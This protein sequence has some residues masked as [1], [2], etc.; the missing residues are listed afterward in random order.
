MDTFNLKVNA[1]KKHYQATPYD[2]QKIRG[3]IFKASLTYQIFQQ[4]DMSNKKIV[5]V[6]CSTSY[7]GDY[8]KE[9]YPTY[10]YEGLDINP[11]AVEIAKGKGLKVREGNN[12]C[13]EFPDDYADL[14]I[15]EGVIHH[16]PAPL[17]CFKEL[18]RITK[19]DG[20]ISLYVYNRN[21]IYCLIYK[22]SF[23]IRLLYH[24]RFG[25]QLIAKLVFPLFNKFY[26]QLGN[27]LY[28]KSREIVPKDVAWNIFNDQILTPIAHFFTRQQ[29]INFACSNGLKILSEK[30]SINKQ[31]LMFIFEKI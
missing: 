25:K 12:L 9:N 10:H 27:R 23:I 17:Q 30:R 5:D 31:G 20:L 2:H 18:I 13:L 1:T 22:L 11:R 7:L 19:K 26:V 28:F 15:S 8:L 6:G 4:Y 14:T 21:H 29:I 24:N 16:T 3:E